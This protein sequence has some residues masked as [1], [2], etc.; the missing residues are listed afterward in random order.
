VSL[1]LALR[2]RRRT[3]MEIVGHSSIEMTMNVSGHV[4]ASADP[5]HRQIR[6]PTDTGSTCRARP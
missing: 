1:P 2:A 3:V 6:N 5:L 4:S